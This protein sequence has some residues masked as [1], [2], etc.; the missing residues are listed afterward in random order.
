MESV[1]KT[2][3]NKKQVIQSNTAAFQKGEISS[4]IAVEHSKQ[5]IKIDRVVLEVY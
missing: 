4:K 5:S 1:G 3:N 2:M